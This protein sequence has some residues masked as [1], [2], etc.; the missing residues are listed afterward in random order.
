MG[1]NTGKETGG[2]AW[3]LGLVGGTVLSSEVFSA[4]FVWTLGNDFDKLH[5]GV[6][7]GKEVI[8]SQD[9]KGCVRTSLPI[10]SKRRSQ[11]GTLWIKR[12]RI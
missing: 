7:E 5:I 4:L 11:S 10:I 2:K 12:K 8:L 3:N 9:R 1:G 6:N